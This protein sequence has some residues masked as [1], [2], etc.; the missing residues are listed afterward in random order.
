[1]ISLASI[2]NEF[3]QKN[4]ENVNSILRS[5]F[6]FITKHKSFKRREISLLIF[7][8]IYEKTD[9]NK[10][11]I[12]SMIE[13]AQNKKTDSKILLG[14]VASIKYLIGVNNS[15]LQGYLKSE[16][17]QNSKII[18]MEE[19]DPQKHCDSKN[20][21]NLIK[22]VLPLFSLLTP[23]LKIMCERSVVDGLSKL[24]T[25][26][27]VMS[28]DCIISL[29]SSVSSP[30]FYLKNQNEINFKIRSLIFDQIDLIISL[31]D[32]LV[33]VNFFFFPKSTKFF[34]VKKYIVEQTI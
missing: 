23:L 1:M 14:L 15:K 28:S 13:L 34:L 2:E 21:E 10:L 5:I 29:L 20:V 22:Y 24:P 26:L 11:L 18:E 12:E 32:E 7:K 8:S 9:K 6:E 19:R 30:L 3:T 25:K 17:N 4:V 31:F 33:I 16:S 27:T